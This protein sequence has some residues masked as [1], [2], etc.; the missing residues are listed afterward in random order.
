MTTLAAKAGAAGYAALAWA[1]TLAINCYCE[2]ATGA[3]GS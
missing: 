2:R 1:I 3:C